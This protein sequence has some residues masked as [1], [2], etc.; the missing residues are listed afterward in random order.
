VICHTDL[1]GGNLMFDQN[2]DLFLLDWENAM[3]A[4]P[5]HDL[6]FIAGE[7]E[8]W[9]VFL[10]PY[11]KE[12][13]LVTPDPDLLGFYW[14]RRA[15]EDVAGFLARILAEEGNPERD[16]EDVVMLLDNVAWLDRIEEDVDRLRSLPK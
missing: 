6:F 15:L 4:P 16:R 5:E 11:V 7:P 1:H 10:P 13:G 14:Y 9:D 8:S 2:G 12:A 3:L